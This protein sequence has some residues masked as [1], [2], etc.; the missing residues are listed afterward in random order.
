MNFLPGKHYAKI[1]RFKFKISE[2][3][4]LNQHLLK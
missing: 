1:F 3:E 4:I 2:Q